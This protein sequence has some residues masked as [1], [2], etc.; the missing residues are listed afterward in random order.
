MSRN[1]RLFLSVIIVG[2]FLI[3]GSFAMAQDKANPPSPITNSGTSSSGQY[4]SADGSRSST[5]PPSNS[6]VPGNNGAPNGASGQGYQI[7]VSGGN[8]PHSN[9]GTI[10]TATL[11]CTTLT[12]NL[13]QGNTDDPG[14]TDIAQLQTFLIAKGYLTLPDASHFGHFGP[15]TKK[16]VKA[17]QKAYGIE[18]TG[19]VG[20]ITRAKIAALSCANGG[21]GG[22]T[23]TST[24]T[25]STVNPT[26]GKFGDQITLT[27]TNFDSN[28]FVL[29]DGK[30]NDR[31]TLQSSTTIAFHLRP[32]L[33]SD[34][35]FRIQTSGNVFISC[36]PGIINI[37]TSSLPHTYQLSVHN[38]GG[39]SNSV[40]F[41]VNPPNSNSGTST[42]TTT[43]HINSIAPTS[44]PVETSVTLSGSG[45]TA[46]ANAINFSGGEYY[47]LSNLSS[48]DGRTLTFNI[49]AATDYACLH[50][51]P[52]PCERAQFQT[53]PGIHAVSVTNANGQSNSVSFNVTVVGSNSSSSKPVLSS[54][55][56]T[57]GSP[58][59][60]VTITGTGFAT[61]TTN[62]NGV[63]TSTNVVIFGTNFLGL[64]ASN[65]LGTSITFTVPNLANGTYNVAVTNGRGTSNLLQFT[66]T[67][68]SFTGTGG[69]GENSST[70]CPRYASCGAFLQG[71]NIIDALNLFVNQGIIN[72]TAAVNNAINSLINLLKYVW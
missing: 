48:S 23:A 10:N 30:L 46:T 15:R 3:T 21:S 62:F 35:L 67:G 24:P 39:I 12:R 37:A 71:A 4:Y 63:A 56:P 57:S 60:R 72:Q 52:H 40:S 20:P 22:G 7:N 55:A 61:G 25:V 6:G 27:G 32:I 34:C 54:L 17:F 33:V 49:P 43:P 5:P 1:L 45:F 19:F 69:N 26:S 31:A 14:Q 68:S 36:D 9:N 18:E 29:L 44:G 65:A 58:G 13:R 50:L 16:A 11:V 8:P 42:S 38:V 51:N 64:F 2:A 70:T 47:Q 53:Q 59:T 41:T 28:T 66:I